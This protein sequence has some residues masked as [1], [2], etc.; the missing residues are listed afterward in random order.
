MIWHWLVGIS[1]FLF[2]VWANVTYW[3]DWSSMTPA[4]RDEERR[5]MAV[6]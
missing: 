3:R 4:E 1:G 6:W 5:E 2:V